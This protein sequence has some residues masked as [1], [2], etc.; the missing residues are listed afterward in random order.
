L[1]RPDSVCEAFLSAGAAAGAE[2]EPKYFVDTKSFRDGAIVS[3]ST[4][5]GQY[6]LLSVVNVGQTTQLWYAYDEQTRNFVAIKMLLPKY[7]RNAAQM[8]SLKWE[9]KIAGD[10]KSDRLIR[11]FDYVNIDQTPF[12][13][14]EWFPAPNLK[15][16]LSQG[17]AAYAPHLHKIM[18]LMSEAL[19]VLHKKHFVHMDVKPDNFLY[20]PEDQNLK[21]LDFALTKKAAS[22]FS[23]F[24]SFKKK[25]QGTASYMSSEQILSKGV[26]ERSDV[27]S[28]GCTFYE[29][30]TGKLP[31][32]GNS[33]N[34]LLQK[35]ISGSVPPASA[36]NR[37]L[38]TEMV[39]LIASMMAKKPDDRPRNCDELSD[40]LKKIRVF[41]RTPAESDVF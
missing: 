22:G 15:M 23:R 7:A 21:L 39:H 26:T 40:Y 4:N 5:Y 31:Y 20:D 12:L 18:I 28:L 13:V 16:V 27:Y 2:T 35:H 29:L 11:I 36:R 9:Q 3:T 14:M 38:T 24:F 37:N 34:E 25:T 30:L 32:T 41:K 10:L 19:A 1:N 33:L 6:R 8:A 17:Y